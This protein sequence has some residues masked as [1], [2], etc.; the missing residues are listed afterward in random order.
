[1]RADLVL[2]E[3]IYHHLIVRQRSNLIENK[4]YVQEDTRNSLITEKWICVYFLLP[5][6]GHHL[7]MEAHA[8]YKVDRGPRDDG[9]KVV[10]DLDH[11]S[12]APAE[13]RID[14]A[15]ED[16]SWRSCC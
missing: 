2:P 9:F 12:E 14:R 4:S 8:A 13:C 6:E 7:V 10:F 3:L 11:A 15:G 5:S 16:L 1:M